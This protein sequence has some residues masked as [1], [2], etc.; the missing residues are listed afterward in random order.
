MI[1]NIFCIEYIEIY[2][3][4]R[5]N[6]VHHICSRQL[7]QCCR[8]QQFNVEINELVSMLNNF[9]ALVPQ[10]KLFLRYRRFRL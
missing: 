4:N 3:H 6:I 8:K 7:K 2:S 1:K 10:M 9:L 5:M